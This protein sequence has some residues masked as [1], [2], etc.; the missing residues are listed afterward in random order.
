LPISVRTT[1]G[2]ITYTLD[3]VVLDKGSFGDVITNTTDAHVVYKLVPDAQIISGADVSG[4]AK[5][6]DTSTKA[7]FDKSIDL[8]SGDGYS[9][10]AKLTE[11]TNTITGL[12]FAG[13]KDSLTNGDIADATLI[14]GGAAVN[15]EQSMSAGRHKL[16][17]DSDKSTMS[18]STSSKSV[19]TTSGTI[20]YTL[21]NTPK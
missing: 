2:T 5:I 4:N 10:S 15:L 19:G 3:K 12:T 20:T 6:G 16:T 18:L 8:M 13:G 17:F 7:V 1:S 11:A 9:I 14:N 21:A